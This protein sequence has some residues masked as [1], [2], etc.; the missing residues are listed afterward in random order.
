MEKLFTEELFYTGVEVEWSHKSRD[1]FTPEFGCDYT[2]VCSC[3]YTC[4]IPK[5]SK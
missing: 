4:N 2:G 5:L 3:L 1:K